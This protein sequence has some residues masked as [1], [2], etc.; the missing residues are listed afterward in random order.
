MADTSHEGLKWV[1]RAGYGARGAIY[2]IIGIIAF[3]AAFS[4]QQAEG[5]KG[6]L[7]TLKTEPMGTV[8][9]WA[10]G[11]G[12]FGYMIWRVTAG[13]ADVEDH[14][15]DAKGLVARTGQVTT[16]LIH[17]GIGVSIIGLAYGSSGQGGGAEDWT[18]TVMSMPGGRILVGIGALILGGAGV[19]YAYKGWSG[20]YRE[21]LQASSTL[22][23]LDPALKA[24]LIIYGGLLALVAVSIF[25]AALNANPGEA[26][27]LGEA[28][29]KLRSVAY[30][31]FLLAGAG[32]GLIAFALYNFCE[33]AY[34]VIPRISG[35]NVTTLKAALKS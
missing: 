4:A 15:T 25:F 2:V 17:A 30:G 10:I 22:T 33:A 1:M 19:Y 23:K 13:I 5:T 11:I 31:R 12:L 29:Q 3:W 6:A 28:L 7:A 8:A 16:G 18:Q 21:H 27:G 14:G 34:R 9:L 26:G 32:L 24:G 20:K 35:A